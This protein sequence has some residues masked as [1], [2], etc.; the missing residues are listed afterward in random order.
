MTTTIEDTGLA[1]LRTVY[2]VRDA[3]I[4][5]LPDLATALTIDGERRD[6]PAMAVFVANA[7][8]FGGGM[9]AAPGASVTDGLLEILDGRELASVLAHEIGH[10][11]HRDL[12]IMGLADVMSRLVS[13]ASWMGQLLVLVN[14][15]L[16]MAGMV[17]VPWSV[18][19]LL[20]FA[21]TLM[22]LTP[23]SLIAMHFLPCVLRCS[24]P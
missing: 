9:R 24:V 21:P 17:H 12:W 7:E 23:V 1:D 2:A 16:V 3:V 6:L 5:R 14:L 15:P 4:G 11:A 8:F 18:V 19:V 10:I 13:L 22:A 20:I